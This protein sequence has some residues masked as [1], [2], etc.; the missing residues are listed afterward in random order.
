MFCGILFVCTSKLH[1]LFLYCFVCF[2]EIKNMWNYTNAA[3]W[4]AHYDD[5]DK[6]FKPPTSLLNVR[7]WIYRVIKFRSYICM[8]AKLPAILDLY[9]R[10][11]QRKAPKI[12]K[13]SCQPSYKMFSLLPH[14][15]QYQ[16]AKSRSKRHINNFYHK[17]LEQLIKW[18][19]CIVH[20]PPPIFTLLLLCLLSMHSHFTSTNM[21]ILP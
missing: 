10:R 9:T 1:V 8:I 16:S 14:G 15:K 5:R 18:T 3:P 21:Y 6:P 4:S 19:I 12:P 20:N 2:T 17:T 11:C 13:D 7:G